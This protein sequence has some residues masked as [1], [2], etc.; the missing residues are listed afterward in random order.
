MRCP[1]G[2]SS[3]S[4]LG[5]KHDV[6][7]FFLLF[8]FLFLHSISEIWPHQAVI[9]LHLSY[10]PLPVNNIFVQNEDK[11]LFLLLLVC[12]LHY[13]SSWTYI[14]Y[15]KHKWQVDGLERENSF[16]D[17][18]CHISFLKTPASPTH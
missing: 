14:F 1:T 7:L 13:S 4:W 5:L 9:I 15:T 2:S 11:K 6:S 16:F 3:R 12:S 18:T 17:H 8:F 10:C